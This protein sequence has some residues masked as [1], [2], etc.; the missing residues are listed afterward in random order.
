MKKTKML[1]AVLSLAVLATIIAGCG[2]DSNT[3]T[4]APGALA[5]T[6]V[7]PMIAATIGTPYSQSL[8]ASGGTAPYVWALAPGSIALPAWLTLSTT[9]TL[10]GTPP[11]GAVT[12]NF[13]VMVTDTAT[14]AGNATKALSIPVGSTPPVFD[15]LA[16]YNASCINTGAGCH[17]ALGVRT[18]AQITTAIA[19]FSPMTSRFSA[20]GSTPLTAAQITAIAAASH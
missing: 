7:S 12:A 11:T 19:S 17:T 10:S 15:A 9:G 6:T 13:T 4:T 18:A 1:F 16:F 5:V 8:T 3:T 14:P 20:T 2:S